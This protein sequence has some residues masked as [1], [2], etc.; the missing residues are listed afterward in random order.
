MLIEI[1]NIIEENEYNIYFAYDR[2][3]MNDQAYEIFDLLNCGK[4]IFIENRK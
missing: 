4:G 3:F 2:K 1:S